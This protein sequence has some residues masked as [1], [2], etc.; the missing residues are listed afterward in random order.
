MQNIDMALSAA[1]NNN[2]TNSESKAAKPASILI[3]DDDKTICRTI[4]VFLRSKKYQIKTCLDANQALR[5]LENETFDL[6]FLDLNMPNLSGIDVLRDIR[7]KKSAIEL[8]VIMLT[9]SD[10]TDDVVASLDAGANDYIVKPGSLPILIARIESQLS[11][12]AMNEALLLQNEDLERKVLNTEVA[13]ELARANLESEMDARIEME[14]ALHMSEQR[15]RELYDNMPAMYF[16]LDKLGNIKS[17]NRF[18]AY[19]LGYQRNELLNKPLFA[20]YHPQDRNLARQYIMETIEDQQRLHC[21]ELR[22]VQK[23]G[24]PI[25]LR[26]TVRV[27]KHRDGSQSVLMVCAEPARSPGKSET[28]IL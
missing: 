12:K 4:E 8:P 22:K 27:I 11:L 10:Q 2:D 24:T 14:K 3:I 25:L 20:L 15:Y 18:G 5:L 16:N 6:V 7:Q 28:T 26:E 19:L 21:W 9:V 17:L 13:Y 23:D 1:H